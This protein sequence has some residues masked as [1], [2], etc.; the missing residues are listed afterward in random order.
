MIILRVL[1]RGI[2]ISKNYTVRK[3]RIRQTAALLTALCVRLYTFPMRK[4][5][6]IIFLILFS[7]ILR[8]SKI[9]GWKKR[10]EREGRKNNTISGG[11]TAIQ[12]T[13]VY[14]VVHIFARQRCF[15]LF[16]KESGGEIPTQ[17]QE[18]FCRYLLGEKS[19]PNGAEKKRG[20][21]LGQRPTSRQSRLGKQTQKTPARIS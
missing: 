5:V 14:K 12:T 10:E 17:S 7:Y 6:A 8:K 9:E 13:H 11:G 15:V 20:E 16:S 18:P 21:E 19:I 2:L 1:L 3:L 4:E